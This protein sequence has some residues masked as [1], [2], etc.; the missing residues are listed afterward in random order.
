[1]Q[2]ESRNCLC[3]FGESS[4][5]CTVSFR[6]RSRWPIAY[7][8][9]TN[10]D[11]PQEVSSDAP[12][13]DNTKA[14]DKVDKKLSK[15][16]AS[17]STPKSGSG[18]SSTSSSA[19]K[20]GKSKSSSS[21]K[22]DMDAFLDRMKDENQ[23]VIKDLMTETMQACMNQLRAEFSQVSTDSSA[24]GAASTSRSS[25]FDRIEE[26]REVKGGDHHDHEDELE[27]HAGDDLSVLDEGETSSHPNSGG[28]NASIA[29]SSM[30]AEFE[31]DV[32]WISVLKQLPSYYENLVGEELDSPSHTSFVAQ[33]FQTQSKP[34]VPRLPLD[35]LMK[36]KWDNIDKYVKTGNVS[37]ATT[38]NS[39]KFMVVESDFEKYSRVPKLD[40]EYTA[41]VGPKAKSGTHANQ[42]NKI[43]K[44]LKVAEN[45]LLKCDESARV[46]LRAA[47]HGSLMVNAMN[48]IM[49]EPDKFQ[50]EEVV[51]LIHGTF[52]TFEA[53]ADCAIRVTARS[54]LARRRIHLSQVSFKD[55]N[56]QKNL[57]QLPMDGNK[58][59]HGEFS[60]I[61]HRYATMARDA[62]ETSDYASAKSNPKKR[63][64]P[65]GSGTNYEPQQKKA[66]L[67]KGPANNVGSQGQSQ[68]VVNKEIGQERRVFK[69]PFPK[70]RFPR[71][72]KQ[73]P[74][75]GNTKFSKQ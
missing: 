50:P 33:T 6:D 72:G 39:K 62:R 42:S 31:N 61:M 75:R 11:N 34:K 25:K 59:F 71:G 40:Q 4:E 28:D 60:E 23:K 43:D 53:I 47:S 54:I 57:L 64:F 22:I 45:D 19:S 74:K 1:M 12:S 5:F 2:A 30:S 68:I 52:K 35:G 41:L 8:M 10:N 44:D 46:I 73:F 32:Q 24:A 16:K 36:Q 20:S 21:S 15:P 49:N 69:T 29:G 70:T 58:L 13:E 27:V 14:K 56:A 67:A 9:S 38:A 37:P 3:I 7:N 63:G 65:G 55:Q 48:T 17:G 66:A 51:N 18:T 26:D